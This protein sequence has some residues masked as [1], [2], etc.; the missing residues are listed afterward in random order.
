M[1]DLVIK[2]K[3]KLLSK[4]NKINNEEC[5]QV[6][7]MAYHFAWEKDYPKSNNYFNSEELPKSKQDA[8]AFVA[9]S[10]GGLSHLHIAILTNSKDNL[11]QLIK[12]G[13][14]DVNQVSKIFPET[15]L[16]RVYASVMV[17]C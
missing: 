6:A 3:Y 14:C 8:E 4:V 15:P 1:T 10:P 2:T 9:A 5:F 7:L 13:Y 12:D 17:K 11:A 16:E